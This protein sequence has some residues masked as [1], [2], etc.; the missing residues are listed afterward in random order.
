M[1]VSRVLR[2]KAKFTETGMVIGS[3]AQW[4]VKAAVLN[5]DRQVVDAGIALSHQATIIE[6]PVLVAE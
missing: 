2:L 4:P 3:S 6:F 5:A 1:S